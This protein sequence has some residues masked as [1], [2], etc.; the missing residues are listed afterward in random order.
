MV[1][2]LWQQNKLR[3]LVAGAEDAGLVGDGLL[4]DLKGIE[5][6]APFG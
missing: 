5:D 1:A 2:A 3:R 6:G 4:A